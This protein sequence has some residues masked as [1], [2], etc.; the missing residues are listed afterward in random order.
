MVETVQ[1]PSYLVIRKAVPTGHGFKGQ[2]EPLGI[3]IQ[4]NKPVL[5]I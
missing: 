4:V 3:W 2:S 5:G 1:G